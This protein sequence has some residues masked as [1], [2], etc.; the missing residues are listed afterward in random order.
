MIVS[1]VNFSTVND[2]IRRLVRSFS[3]PMEEYQKRQTINEEDVI[4]A[5]DSLEF[6]FCDTTGYLGR[7]KYQHEAYNVCDDVQ[8]EMEEL[9]IRGPDERKTILKRRLNLALFTLIIQPT[10][11]LFRQFTHADAMSV[12]PTIIDQVRTTFS[13]STDY[14]SSDDAEVAY[15]SMRELIQ[16]IEQQN[17]IKHTKRSKALVIEQ[18]INDGQRADSEDVDD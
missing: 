14:C 13:N 7:S 15:V 5:L 3:R 4:N 11:E 10:I 2:G 16:Q 1:E 8:R 6:F 9:L 17:K 12:A 18:E